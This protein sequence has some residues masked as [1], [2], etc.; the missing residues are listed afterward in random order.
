[1]PRRNHKGKKGGYS[2]K[3]E[4][5]INIDDI[6]KGKNL[7]PSRVKTGRQGHCFARQQPTGK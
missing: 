4:H 7:P 3:N 6:L 1:M 5:P 2:P